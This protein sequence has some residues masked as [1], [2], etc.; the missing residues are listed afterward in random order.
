MDLLEYS[1]DIWTI[2]FH[3][4]GEDCPLVGFLLD[5]GKYKN[6]KLKMLSLLDHVSTN[7]PRRRDDFSKHLSGHIFEFKRGPKNGAKIRI[8]YFYDENKIIICTH[9][10]MKR[11]ETPQKKIKEA[12]KIRSKYIEAKK[13]G[14][15]NIL[16]MEGDDED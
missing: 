13:N 9:V 4:K 16:E 15:I 8:L 14:N 7:G 6:E 11:E 12:E 2:Y 5:A 10:F 3:A 1:K